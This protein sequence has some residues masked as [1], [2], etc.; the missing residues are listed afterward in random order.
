VALTTRSINTAQYVALR[1]QEHHLR[2]TLKA[3]EQITMFRIR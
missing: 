2:P 1:W 3:T